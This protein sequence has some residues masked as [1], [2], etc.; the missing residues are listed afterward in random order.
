MYYIN[1]GKI[2]SQDTKICNISKDILL[3][4][5]E[6]LIPFSLNT[7]TLSRILNNSIFEGISAVSDIA[8]T[9][10]TNLCNSQ[11]NINDISNWESQLYNLDDINNS[12]DNLKEEANEEEE[13]NV[14]ETNV[15]EDSLESENIINESTLNESFINVISQLS[16]INN[17]D[18]IYTSN[19]NYN[20]IKENYETEYNNMK[21]MGFTN[22]NKILQSLYICNGNL[23]EATN[24]YLSYQ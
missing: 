9:P 17:L 22:E 6:N 1:N 14:E 10:L 16:N 21:N 20:Q 19:I 8:N 12:N 24:Y 4:N 3:I 13:A 15:E 7:S 5:I 2:I 11:F 18:N 23:E